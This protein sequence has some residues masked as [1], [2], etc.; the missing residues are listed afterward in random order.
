MGIITQ[1]LLVECMSHTLCMA[2]PCL[3]EFHPAVPI[4]PTETKGEGGLAG[5]SSGLHVDHWAHL[6]SDISQRRWLAGRGG[7]KEQ[8]EVD[9]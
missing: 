9:G 3:C 2:S 7:E 8:D 4:Q 6:P 5:G 1:G